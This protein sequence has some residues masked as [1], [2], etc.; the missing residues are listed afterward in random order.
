MSAM[1][2]MEE[3]VRERREGKR[4]G[5][6][7]QFVKCRA[8]EREHRVRESVSVRVCVWCAG[9]V[10]HFEVTKKNLTDETDA[11]GATPPV[12]VIARACRNMPT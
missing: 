2:Q 7:Y 5:D 11:F 1:T 8:C 12:V 3:M 9:R 4:R 6:L 10:R